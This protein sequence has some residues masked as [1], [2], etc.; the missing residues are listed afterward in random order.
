MSEPDP[1]K[2]FAALKGRDLRALSA[3]RDG[4][5]AGLGKSLVAVRFLARHPIA[6]SPAA[7]LAAAPEAPPPARGGLAVKPAPEPPAEIRLLVIADRRDVWIEERVDEAALAATIETAA[8]I[9]PLVYSAEEWAAPL[10][11]A[12]PL[13]AVAEGAPEVP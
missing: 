7:T 2:A 1:K 13:R 12:M 3:F 5:R 4:L 9:V 10:A 11:M 8:V 6:L